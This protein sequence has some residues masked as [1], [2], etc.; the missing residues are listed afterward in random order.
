MAQGPSSLEGGRVWDGGWT[1]RA[2]GPLGIAPFP[3]PSP[4]R[5]TGV[6]PWQLLPITR[7]FGAWLEPRYIFG[8]GRL[9]LDQ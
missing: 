4:V 5:G 8:A 9:D 6:E 2:L 3:C 7:S 1:Q